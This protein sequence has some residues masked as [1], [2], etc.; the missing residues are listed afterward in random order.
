MRQ[1]NY[2]FVI[3]PPVATPLSPFAQRGIK[4]DFVFFAIVK[5]RLKITVD[6]FF[7]NFAGK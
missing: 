4:G 3:N 5:I 2:F 7:T 6:D 1:N